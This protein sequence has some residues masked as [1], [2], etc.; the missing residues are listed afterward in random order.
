MDIAEAIIRIDAAHRTPEGWNIQAGLTFQEVE[1]MLDRLEIVGIR[2]REI[3]VQNDGTF[4]VR[5]RS[6]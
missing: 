5:W 6:E 2:A 4:E 3:V 1:V